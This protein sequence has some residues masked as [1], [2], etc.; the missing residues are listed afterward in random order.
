MLRILKLKNFRKH[1]DKEVVFG[2]GLTAIKGA[3]EAGKTTV[4]E[5]VL[6]ALYGSTALRDPLADVVTWGCKDTEL[7]VE[8]T[9]EI[10][11]RLY[12]FKR[13]KSGA[14][15]EYDGGLVTGQKEVTNHATSVIGADM[16]TTSRLMLANQNA[17]RGALEDG[18]KAV[19]QQIEV[20]ADFDLFDR[21][22]SAADQ[23]LTTGSTAVAEERVKEAEVALAEAEPEPPCFDAVEL[24]IAQARASAASKQHDIETMTARKSVIDGDLQSA[25][26]TRRMR[27]ALDG[28]LRK[29]R[30]ALDLH[31]VQKAD[32]DAKAA[33]KW[34]TEKDITDAKAALA[35]AEGHAQR[36][37]VYAQFQSLMAVYPAAY[38]EGSKES[39]EAEV[40]TARKSKDDALV[41]LGKQVEVG[42]DLDR[43]L[44]EL[45]GHIVT[46][47]SC[48]TCGQELKDKAQ[49]E[50]H[51]AST[52]A[53]IDGVHAAMVKCQEFWKEA[54][55]EVAET[56]GGLNE[57]LAV[58]K[59]AG[60]FEGFAIR[61]GAYVD[62]G[63]DAYPPKLIWKG[64]EPTAGGHDAQG[65]RSR[66]VSLQSAK[67]AAERANARSLALAQTL[68]EDEGSI[69][70]LDGQLAVCPQP[71]DIDALSAEAREVS[72]ALLAVR[73]EIAG[74]SQRERELI[75]QMQQAQL[76]YE[77]ALVRRQSLKDGLERSRKD[78]DQLNF[79]NA[80]LKKIRAARPLIA[81]KLWNTV[82]SS[83]S[84]MFS[85]MRGETSV[86]SK[87]KDGFKV[88]GKSVT[89]FS[90]ST[91]DLLGLAIRVALVKTFLPH[92]SFVVLDEPAHGCDDT[93]TESMLGFIAA[94]GFQQ[95]L[96][97]SHE[98]A[99]EAAAD[100]LIAI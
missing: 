64:E 88:N 47:T 40:V 57:L 11:G 20:L 35:D 61:H 87:D 68:E 25:E 62:V 81:D 58:A 26:N 32:A 9:I 76:E 59:S 16:T 77:R 95:I 70:R 12:N 6:Y 69:A 52:N 71:A 82:L 17:L 23:K 55:R 22:I 46:A 3:N 15:C 53:E 7:K 73:D 54:E 10:E 2:T 56:D 48:P 44:R 85:Q 78:L 91:L 41:R 38:W 72:N 51:N 8:L 94:T 66:I 49:I 86:V 31:K 83:V 1:T 37:S 74:Y 84:T 34:G 67:E 79:N 65:L 21:I 24:Q 14:E 75:S 5:A 93:R 92:T 43:R 42:K 98:A 4:I 50:A 99:T 19:A 18:P 63:L 60:P 100:H 29:A 90:G 89:S 80:L 36:L 39:F 28:N 27:D 96:I 97:V 13:S 45:N 33:V 30:E